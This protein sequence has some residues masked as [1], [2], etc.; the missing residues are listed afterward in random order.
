MRIFEV[1]YIPE[2]GAFHAFDAILQRENEVHRVAIHKIKLV[3]EDLGVVLYELTGNV[4]RFRELMADL[5]ADFD[6]QITERDG[7][8]FFYSSF[9]PNDT[10]GQLI[11]ITDEFELFRIPP[12]RF[13]YDGHLAST[14]VGTH[15]VFE[16]AISTVPSDVTVV[17]D[18]KSPYSPNQERIQSQLTQKQQAILQVAIERGYYD[19]P[20]GVSCAELGEEFGLTGATVGEHLRKAEQSIMQE[21]L[22]DSP[23][24]V[25]KTQDFDETATRAKSRSH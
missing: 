3:D 16:E 18:R 23:T 13:E 11:R 24:N 14:Y 2:G 17:L 21:F 15:D 6:Y 22:S 25:Y 4:R 10:L 20:R 19:I 7:S 8:I 1:R 12:M 5:A 9:R